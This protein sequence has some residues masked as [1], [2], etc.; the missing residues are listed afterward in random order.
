M[1]KENF[2]FYSN[3]GFA[4]AILFSDVLYMLFPSMPYVF[5]VIA[6]SLFVLC[7]LSNLLYM[8]IKKK[9]NYIPNYIIL[10]GII[11]AFLGDVLLID[12]F[13]IG[14]IFF[15]IGHI[16]FLIAFYFYE[17]FSIWDIVCSA[18]LILFSMLVIF[19][20]KGFEWYGMKM[21]VV[22]YAII[23]SIM[24]GKAISNAILSKNKPF[25]II[26]MLGAILFFISDMMLLFNNFARIS[27]IFDY[28]C[29][30]TYYPG[31]FLLALSV[32]ISFVYKRD[33]KFII[34]SHKK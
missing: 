24:L 7:A 5:K 32:G 26:I 4:T 11:C 9:F 6:S 23:I 28:I 33:S 18:I 31:V 21:I 3:I 17:K 27:P 16:F 29:L 25:S 30:A 1:K 8:I 34:K 10:A 19:L 13:M 14:A 2:L 22:I 12:Y 15:A 20:Y